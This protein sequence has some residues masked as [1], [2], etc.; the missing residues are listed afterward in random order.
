MHEC[1]GR[2]SV[3]RALCGVRDC[4]TVPGSKYLQLWLSVNPVS[5]NFCD[6]IGRLREQYGFEFA[7]KG[8]YMVMLKTRR[9]GELPLTAYLPPA[10]TEVQMRKEAK[11]KAYF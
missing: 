4:N 5:G 1:D 10:L 9:M 3:E 7:V 8:V 6:P 11:R 2:C